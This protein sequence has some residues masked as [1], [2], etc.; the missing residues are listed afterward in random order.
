M[1][2][3][4]LFPKVSDICK[5]KNYEQ[6]MAP[7]ITGM[8]LDFTVFEVSDVLEFLEN[9]NYLKEKVVEAFNLLEE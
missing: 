1:L 4:M 3:N 6:E 5:A 2:G 9:E 8:L 7:K